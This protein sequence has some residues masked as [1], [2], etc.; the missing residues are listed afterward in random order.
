MFD[1]LY[2][3]HKFASFDLVDGCGDECEAGVDGQGRPQRRPSSRQRQ[4]HHAAHIAATGQQVRHQRQLTQPHREGNG[5]T[6][7]ASEVGRRRQRVVTEWVRVL[8]AVCVLSAYQLC[9][10]V[11]VELWQEE[12]DSMLRQWLG[13]VDVDEHA[14]LWGSGGGGRGGGGGGGGGR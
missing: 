7:E 2:A 13:E 1:V 8:R 5:S 14:G 6:G 3:G 4:H 11:L 9:V 12:E 10:V